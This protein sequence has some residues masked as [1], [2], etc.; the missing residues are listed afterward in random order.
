MKMRPP[1][2]WARARSQSV[3]VV[4]YSPCISCR[5]LTH[6][7]RVLAAG[8]AVLVSLDQALG[9]SSRGRATGELLVESNNPLHARGIGGTAN[10][11]ETS[12]SVFHS[13]SVSSMSSIICFASIQGSFECA[14]GGFGDLGGKRDGGSG[15]RTLGEATCIHG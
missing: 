11:L 7:A 12:L 4:L 3:S 6:G 5:E 14:V 8:V 9:L 15:A 2:K 1:I 10:G 13:S